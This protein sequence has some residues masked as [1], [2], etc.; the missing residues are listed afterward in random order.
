MVRFM[1]KTKPRLEEAVRIGAKN[2]LTIPRRISRA[3][4][5]KKGD[6]MLMRLVGGRVEMIP[7]SL[8]PKDQLWFWTPEWQKKEREVDEA[9]A[10]GDYKETDSVDELL[11][12]LKS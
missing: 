6:H 2:Q 11:K 5:L 9:L 10:R 4:R 1:P 8:I 12:D 7:V 3:L